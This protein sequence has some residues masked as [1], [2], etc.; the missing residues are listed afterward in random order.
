MRTITKM[1]SMAEKRSGDIDV[2]EGKMRKLR[3]GSIT[4]DSREGSPQPYATPQSNKASLRGP[5]ASTYGLFYTPDSTRDDRRGL[6]NSFMSST[7][8]SSRGSPGPRK[9]LSGY[10]LEEKAQLRA[11]LAKKNDVKIRLRAALEK[12]GTT[13]RPMDDE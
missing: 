8:P 12:A 10:S 9:K 2:L 1:T 3:F 5:N 7:G 13:V 4:S 11:N 6:Q